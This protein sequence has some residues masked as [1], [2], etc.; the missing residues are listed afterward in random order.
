M[1]VGGEHGQIDAVAG[2]PGNR[3][4]RFVYPDGLGQQSIGTRRRRDGQDAV[5][6][7]PAGGAA[8]Q[9]GNAIHGLAVNE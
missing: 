2:M 7:A 6:L 3:A 5:G 1:R 4:E 9:V 8:D